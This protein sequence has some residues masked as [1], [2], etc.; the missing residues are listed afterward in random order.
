MIYTDMADGI[1][2][3]LTSVG[4]NCYSEFHSGKI[5]AKMQFCTVGIKSAKLSAKGIDCSGESF[6]NCEC[7]VRV[8]FYRRGLSEVAFHKAVESNIVTP[9]FMWSGDI[10]SAEVGTASYDKNLDMLKCEVIVV[11]KGIA[12]V[13]QG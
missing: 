9:L 6:V 3:C 11:F 1:S 13:V 2:S 5:T 10:L 7:A 12:G 8:T 4:M